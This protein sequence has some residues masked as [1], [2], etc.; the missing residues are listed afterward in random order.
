MVKSSHFHDISFAKDNFVF[1]SRLDNTVN[2][3][4]KPN[5]KLE[6]N[7][8]YISKNIQGPAE[9]TSLW[10]LDAGLKWTFL[11]NAAELRLKGTDMFN[12]WTPNMTMKYDTQNLRMDIIP[13]ARAVS[14]SFTFKL[15]N[16]DK[17]RKEFDSSRYGTK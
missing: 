5:I 10:R 3:S 1:Y 4:S 11:R 14:L 9:L 16:Y 6:I 8:A 2:I 17:T 15:G 13:D 12:S 7:G